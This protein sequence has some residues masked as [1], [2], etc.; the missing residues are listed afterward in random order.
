MYLM[1][2]CVFA[3]DVKCWYFYRNIEGLTNCQIQM[4]FFRIPHNQKIK[5]LTYLC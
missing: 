2:F 1:Q 5:T 4:V 3:F